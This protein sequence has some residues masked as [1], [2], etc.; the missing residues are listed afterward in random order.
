MK[1]SH[2]FILEII[3]FWHLIMRTKSVRIKVQVKQKINFIA[4]FISK[5]IILC[6]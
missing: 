2:H 3:E 5:T 4:G 1:L 6:A